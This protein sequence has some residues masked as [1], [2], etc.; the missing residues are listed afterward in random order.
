MPPVSP[1]FGWT[2]SGLELGTAVALCS[3]VLVGSPTLT[4]AANSASSISFVTDDGIPIAAV[5][6]R[7][8]IVD[9][10]FSGCKVVGL[11]RLCDGFFVDGLVLVVLLCMMNV[12]ILDT[13]VLNVLS[14]V[15]SSLL[16]KTISRKN[17]GGR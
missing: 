2:V 13:L 12:R 8:A 14:E 16:K 10:V 5:D 6:F 17:M 7:R 1:V 15:K 11:M 4:E 3:F 9:F